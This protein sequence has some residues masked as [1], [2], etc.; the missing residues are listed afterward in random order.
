MLNETAIQLTAVPARTAE[1]DFSEEA[2]TLG[3]RV[4]GILTWILTKVGLEEMVATPKSNVGRWQAAT[5]ISLLGLVLYAAVSLMSGQREVGRYQQ[6]VEQQTRDIKKNEE[7][8]AKINERYDRDRELQR[9]I[10]NDYLN[11]FREQI[12]PIIREEIQKA[13]APS[14]RR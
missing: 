9:Q 8:I 2:R 4:R 1:P 6:M 5:V 14:P 12:G 7:A 11:Q 13:Q 3:E 10:F